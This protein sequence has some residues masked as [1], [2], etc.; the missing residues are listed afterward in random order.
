MTRA[1]KSSVD[2]SLGETK[3]RLRPF[4]RGLFKRFQLLQSRQIISRAGWGALASLP[5][6]AFAGPTGESV[7][8]GAVDVL[9][10]NANR[11]EI[12][13]TSQNAIVNWNT[14]SIDGNEF[15]LI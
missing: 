15:V 10:P 8:A 7:A 3:F 14:F 6:L 12:N 4:S 9:R 5:G 2:K 11:T 13:Q 1:I